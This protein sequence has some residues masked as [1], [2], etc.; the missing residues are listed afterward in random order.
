MKHLPDKE[1]HLAPCTNTSISNPVFLLI[2]ATSRKLHSLAR[3]IR[4]TPNSFHRL[5]EEELLTDACVLRCMER[6][7][8]RHFLI[9]ARS[10][11]I[12]ASTPAVLS[13][14]SRSS[15]EGNSCSKMIMLTVQ[16]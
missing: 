9:T 3:T 14:A 10:Q 13:A 8:S 11:Q 5:A 6:P 2:S 1:I 12:T 15:N 7:N 4:V 16:Y